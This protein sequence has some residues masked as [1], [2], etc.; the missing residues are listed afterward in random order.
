MIKHTKLH[1]SI[2]KIASILGG[3]LILSNFTTF[4]A[5]KNVS[6]NSAIDYF[7]FEL[8]YHDSAFQCG[9]DTTQA[10]IKINIYDKSNNLLTTMSKGDRYRIK[11]F[12][13]A[14][15]LT[16]T[17]NVYNLSCINNGSLRPELDSML[18]GSNDAIP[19]IDGFSEQSS[20]AD[21]LSSLTS[22]E[23]LYLVELGTSNISSSA[24]DLQDVVLVVDNNPA[25][26]D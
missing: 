16:F 5:T 2:K 19:N 8:Y 10:D 25:P 18:L 24:Y 21:M 7:G 9:S 22:Y 13:S 14:S 1:Q 26:I 3:A 23:E 11:K 20:I 4:L 15:D 17:Y 12:D 6:A